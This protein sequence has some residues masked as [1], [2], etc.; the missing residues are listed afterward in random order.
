[1]FTSLISTLDEILVELTAQLEEI[2]NTRG[3]NVAHFKEKERGVVAMA[4]SVA[5]AIKKVLDT[6]ILTEAGEL[7]DESKAV[8]AEMEKYIES[9][10]VADA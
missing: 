9:I 8:H 10:E 2:V 3:T 5:A 6:P 1:M 4:M 7:T